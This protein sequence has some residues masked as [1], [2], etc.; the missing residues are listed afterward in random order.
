MSKPIASTPA[1]NPVTFLLEDQQAVIPPTSTSQTHTRLT[2]TSLTEVTI[3][4]PRLVNQVAPNSPFEATVAQPKVATS[5]L[6]HTVPQARDQ[7]CSSN[8][9]AESTTTMFTI[10]THNS[11]TESSEIAE[12]SHLRTDFGESLLVKFSDDVCLEYVQTMQD[13]E[14]SVQ[15]SDDEPLNYFHM[16]ASQNCAVQQF[17]FNS[18]HDSDYH[19]QKAVLIAFNSAQKGDAEGQFLLG[20]YFENGSGVKQDSTEAEMLY[21]QAAKQGHARAMHQLGVMY[22]YGIGVKIDYAYAVTW[23]QQAANHGDG[24]AQTSLGMML[25]DGLGVNKDEAMAV[26]WYRKAAHQGERK[27]QREL[28]AAYHEGQGVK[29]DDKLATYWLIKSSHNGEVATFDISRF[30][31]LFKFIPSVLNEFKEFENLT[32][33]SISHSQLMTEDYRA[34]GKIISA[35]TSIQVVNLS[36]CKLND[37]GAKIL[38]KALERNIVLTELIINGKTINPKL[39]VT[40]NKALSENAAIVELRQYVKD[41]SLKNSNYLPLEVLEMV[42]DR[43]IVSYIKSGHSKD[44][45]QNAIDELILSSSIY[46]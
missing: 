23:Y 30:L 32:K 11:I 3:A 35:N 26:S 43:T 24:Q 2:S 33:I 44:A 38:I 14:R 5:E 18:R 28:A 45:T 17:Q 8:L 15:M 6:Q 4:E 19:Q 40:I 1:I 31:N 22:E 27:A 46:F 42:I 21:R 41:Y 12:L 9:S 7:T 37:A 16:E 13:L 29:K 10:A 36:Q 39:Y 34:I 25:L 20:L